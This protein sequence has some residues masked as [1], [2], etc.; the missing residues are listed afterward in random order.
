MGTGRERVEPEADRSVA[1]AQGKIKPLGVD[2]GFPGIGR[3]PGGIGKPRIP[4]ESGTAGL[5]G[6][7]VQGYRRG[8]AVADGDAFDGIF[9]IEVKSKSPDWGEDTSTPSIR[10]CMRLVE[11]PRIETAFTVP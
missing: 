1:P 7:N 9:S 11:S 6:Y 10:T 2:K 5:P 4:G 8:S 3:D